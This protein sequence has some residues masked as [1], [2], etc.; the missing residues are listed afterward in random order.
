MRTPRIFTEQ[1]LATGR[2]VTLE[3]QASRHLCQVLRF[4]SG[5]PLILFNGNGG[6]YQA[7]IQAA[8]PKACQIRID[9]YDPVDRESP[10]HIE[11]GLALSK[12]DRF[13]W[14]LQKATELGVSAIRPLMTERTEVRLKG[15]RLN[16]KMGHWQRALAHACE[17][18]GRNRLPLFREPLNYSDW[19][20]KVD[21][22]QPAYLLHPGLDEEAPAAT[23][24]QLTLAVGPEGG[25]GDGE[26]QAALDAGF[27][28]LSLG[29]R[30]LRTETAPLAALT[31][32]QWRW[33]DLAG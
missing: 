16:K 22:S 27:Q 5:Q 33:G 32:L 21:T 6:E 4:K 7:V 17:Q 30:V 9:S 15:E 13:D 24:Q 31:L 10:L 2:L 26:V 18:S 20:P 25:F 23:P 8:N 1:A 14:A 19:L 11:L 3:Q 29:P 12:G 28:G